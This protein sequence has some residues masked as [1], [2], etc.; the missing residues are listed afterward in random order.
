MLK[1]AFQVNGRKEGLLN[2]REKW[3]AIS[4]RMKLVLYFLL[5]RRVQ[6]GEKLNVNMKQ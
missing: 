5:Y 4:K 6:L 2:K 1:M 3:A